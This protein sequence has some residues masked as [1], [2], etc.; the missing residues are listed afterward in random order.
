MSR[1]T[2]LIARNVFPETVARLSVHFDVD[3]NAEDRGIRMP[4]FFGYMA[5][6]CAILLPLFFVM[7]FIWFR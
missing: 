2:I 3:L 5:W 1:P 7:T 6:S 4:S